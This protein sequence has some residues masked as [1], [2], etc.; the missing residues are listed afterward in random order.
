M[1]EAESLQGLDKRIRA[2]SGALKRKVCAGEAE[3]VAT[4]RTTL[5]T[6]IWSGYDMGAA[7]SFLRR[8]RSQ[9]KSREELEDEVAAFFLHT[10]SQ[11]LGAMSVEPSGPHAAQAIR[12]VVEWRV[13]LWLR[14]QNCQCGVAPS[15]L[16]LVRRAL[17][18][19]PEGL[20]T[21]LEERVR[22]PLEGA[23]RAQRKWLRRFRSGWGA[24]LG[25]LP[26][27][28]PVPVHQLQ[29]KACFFF[30]WGAR[31]RFLRACADLKPRVGLRTPK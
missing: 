24:R 6:Y 16:Q 26:I 23:A 10:P 14:E 2:V 29:E 20:P 28:P 13:F 9:Q 1:T 12:H 4:R 25:Q 27:A 31:A 18:Q 11:E 15:R 22:R 30:Y 17:S 21:E 7:A 3:S 19:V 8:K 5:L